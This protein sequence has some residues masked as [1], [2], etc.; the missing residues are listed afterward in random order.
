MILHC[1]DW[2]WVV[3]PSAKKDNNVNSSYPRGAF[4]ER[5]DPR[6]NPTMPHVVV[7]DPVDAIDA[8]LAE[9]HRQKAAGVRRVSVSD[10]SLQALKV[11]AGVA[12]PAQVRAMTSAQTVVSAASPQPAPL[13]PRPIVVAPPV[14]KV[15][16]HAPELRPLPAARVLTLPAGTKAERLAWVHGQIAQCPVT[17]E[18]LKSPQK[19]VLGVGSAEAKILFVGEAPTLEEVEAGRAF[20]GPAGELL[21]K[22][23]AATGLSEKDIYV[24]SLMGWRPE[25]PTAYGK[26]P[27][28]AAEV[29]FNLPYLRAQIEAIQPQVIVALGAQAFEALIQAKRTITQERGRWHEFEGRPLMPT[30][31]PNYL[32]H[33]S[34]LTAKRT[35]WEDFLLVMEKVGLVPTEKQ[36][37]FFLAPPRPVAT[38]DVEPGA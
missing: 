31:H 10:E 15:T 5:I 24:A 30:F 2:V 38:D 7:I 12:A 28:N 4:G 9:L 3:V 34:S 11:M 37:G 18:H 6:S 14:P 32:L 35:V 29:A 19:P 17:L 23:V 20:V 1:L 21:R 33:N 25:P 27:P 22:I 8:L 13:A 36:R 16:V 26:R